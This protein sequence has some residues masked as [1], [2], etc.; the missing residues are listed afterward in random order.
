MDYK[1]VQNAPS[2]CCTMQVEYKLSQKKKEK[3]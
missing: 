2:V 1:I 3:K